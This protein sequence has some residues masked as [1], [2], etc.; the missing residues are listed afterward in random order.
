MPRF[1][2][3]RFVKALREDALAPFGQ[4][5]CAKHV[6]MALEAAGLD[7]SR[8]PVHAR[9]YGPTL[10]AHGFAEVTV[11]PDAALSGDIAVIQAA[12]A[13]ESGHIQ[14]FDGENWISDFVQRAFWPGPKY[15]TSK[16]VFVIYRHGGK[17]A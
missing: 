12:A 5:V 17:D 10:E 13:G 16:P 14:G 2:R 8:R 9:E 4:G 6:R 1:E 11:E 15:R 3:E 7:M